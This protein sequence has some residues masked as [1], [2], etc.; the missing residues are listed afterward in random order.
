MN[1]HYF[2]FLFSDE[3]IK[4]DFM[5]IINDEYF[6]IFQNTHLLQSNFNVG[7]IDAVNFIKSN[8]N[9]RAVFNA[10]RDEQKRVETLAETTSEVRVLGKAQQMAS[11]GNFRSLV[12]K[13]KE[14]LEIMQ[15]ERQQ[16]AKHKSKREDLWNIV[17]YTHYE[18]R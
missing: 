7:R 16:L 17:Y 2:N 6:E 4:K 9:N 12:S 3:K 10:V 8:S 1:E 11:G 5:K 14:I 13:L 18:R 15:Y